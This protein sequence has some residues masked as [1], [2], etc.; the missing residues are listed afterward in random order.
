MKLNFE[1]L[2]YYIYTHII[3]TEPDFTLD[4]EYESE[5]TEAWKNYFDLK[6][7]YE[8]EIEGLDK[9]SN[10]LIAINVKYA[11]LL[12]NC[13]LEFRDSFFSED[14]GDYVAEHVSDNDYMSLLPMKTVAM[15]YN[16]IRE[17]ERNYNKNRSE[18]QIAKFLQAKSL[19]AMYKKKLSYFYKESF[20]IIGESTEQHF[21]EETLDGLLLETTLDSDKDLKK[22]IDKY[23]LTDKEPWTPVYILTQIS[24]WS[25]SVIVMQ[26]EDYGAY[27]Q[28]QQLQH[29]LFGRDF[30]YNNLLEAPEYA[31]ERAEWAILE[32]VALVDEKYYSWNTLINFLK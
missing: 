15:A 20:Q 25:L 27:Q 24:I 19:F 17:I 23:R 4:L 12:Q 11:E 2:L 3:T 28:I 16:L 6:N 13:L 22:F 5:D 1:G 10:D 7:K 31:T 29:Q 30:W 21:N 14:V 26:L 18:L 32:L 8:K 9:G